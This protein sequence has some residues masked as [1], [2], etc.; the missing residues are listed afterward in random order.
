MLNFVEIAISIK[1]HDTNSPFANMREGN[2]GPIVAAKTANFFGMG[3]DLKEAIYDAH[4]Q[5]TAFLQS[6]AV[7]IGSETKRVIPAV[8]SDL[9]DA[10]R[11]G[12]TPGRGRSDEDKEH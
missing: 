10:P 8:L 2:A 7:L 3:E 1:S 5:A 9:A 11:K 6:D 4:Q 12:F